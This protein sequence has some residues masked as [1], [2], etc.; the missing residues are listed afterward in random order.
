[1]VVG[2]LQDLQG[3]QIRSN[4]PRKG[5]R[6]SFQALETSSLPSAFSGFCQFLHYVH[7][8]HALFGES[9]TNLD[10]DWGPRDFARNDALARIETW[11]VIEQVCAQA[12]GTSLHCLLVLLDSFSFMMTWL[13]HWLRLSGSTLEGTLRN[14]AKKDSELSS[15]RCNLVYHVGCVGSPLRRDKSVSL[16]D[17]DKNREFVCL[18]YR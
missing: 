13:L 11:E 14:Q 10:H 4:S 18:V 1:M 8:P 9:G 16:F 3:G 15:L 17:E 5:S 2:R 6:F 12:L 7:I